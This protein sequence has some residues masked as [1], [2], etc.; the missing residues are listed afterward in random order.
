LLFASSS[1]S[2]TGVD[3]VMGDDEEE[4]EEEEERATMA[5][6]GVEEVEESRRRRWAMPAKGGEDTV[7]AL[8]N[9]PAKAPPPERAPEACRGLQCDTRMTLVRMFF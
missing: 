1:A 5:V 6:F 2:V 4:E 9:A 8:A 7:G 3:G